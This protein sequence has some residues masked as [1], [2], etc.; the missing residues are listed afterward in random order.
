MSE[1]G[2]ILLDVI[3]GFEHVLN[4]FQLPYLNLIYP[5]EVCKA[6]ASKDAKF[7]KKYHFLHPLSE[8]KTSKIRDFA[9]YLNGYEVYSAKNSQY[10]VEENVKKM[11]G[12]GQDNVIQ[13]LQQIYFD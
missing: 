11:L 4:K 12:F 7:E 1:D 9:R 3:E 2:H 8:E 6:L 13:I 5:Q 10:Y